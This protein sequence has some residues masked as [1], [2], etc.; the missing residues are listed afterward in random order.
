MGA[1]PLLPRSIETFSPFRHSAESR[2]A[3]PARITGEIPAWLRGEVI[4]TCPAVFEAPGWRA[5][6]W[7]DG[8]GMIY[9]FRIGDSATDF[10]SHLL[11][12]ETARDALHGE[13][14][15]STFGTRSTRGFLERL[16]K[17]VP[18][19]TD[20]ANVNIVKIGNELV[21]MTE[22]VRPQIIDGETL[23]PV[24]SVDFAGDALAGSI[25]TA[26]PHF[27]FE[28]SRVLNLAT[29]FGVNGVL[30][31][32]EYAP[33]AR[34]RELIGSWQTKR[35][36]YAHTFGVTPRNAILVAHP[37]TVPPMK[38]LFSSKGYIDH[39][40]WQP[41]EGTRLVVMDRATGR[42]S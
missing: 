9:A 15:L 41:E 14:N 27:D 29:Q 19:S 16:F 17:P 7:F 24:G 36:P 28:R 42:G 33:G 40:D 12:S 2:A 10:R 20:N 30:S 31:I 8:L 25:M 22:A 35:V 1:T 26:H 11:D 18:R 4:R 5:Q 13:T 3:I 23:A 39:F 32:C 6:H 21:A 38:M 34:R 37:L